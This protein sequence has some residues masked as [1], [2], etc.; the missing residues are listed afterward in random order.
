MNPPR[1]PLLQ[2][3][4][5]DMYPSTLL[6]AKLLWLVLFFHG[7]LFAMEVPFLP[8]FRPLDALQPHVVAVSFALQ[9]VFFAGGVALLF[10]V[11]PRI[12]CAAIGIAILLLLLGNRTTYRNH[13]FICACAFLLGA[14]HDRDERPWLLVW[15][16]AMLY[17]F[18][19]LNK[20]WEADWRDGQFFDAWL[21]SWVGWYQ[22]G[23][24]RFTPGVFGAILAWGTIAFEVCLGITFLFQRAR[25]VAIWLAAGFHIGLFV[26]LSG[27]TFG[28]FLHSAMVLLV[29]FVPWDPAGVELRV[30]AR[31]MRLVRAALPWAD[32]DRHIDVGESCDG[33]VTLRVNGV[34]EM[35][36]LPALRGVVNRLPVVWIGFV[37]AVLVVPW[38]LPVS[39]VNAVL[40]VALVICWIAYFPHRTPAPLCEMG[41]TVAT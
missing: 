28:F 5:A 13:I 15:Q 14:A 4:G 33:R 23:A 22:W 36:G 39:I 12:A 17:V 24:A 2:V 19:G 27:A 34:G 7:A 9:A 37:G 20:L 3:T 25:P 6:A 18:S 30:P 1:I 21:G 32:H 11:R 31:W 38:Y 8:L 16:V 10:N 35:T 40:A 29:A 41:A 26:L